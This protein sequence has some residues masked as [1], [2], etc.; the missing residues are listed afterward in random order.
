MKI[1]KFLQILIFVIIVVAPLVLLRISR[2]LDVSDVGRPTD[3]GVKKEEVE[4]I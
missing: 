1:R 3:T 2:D 4:Q